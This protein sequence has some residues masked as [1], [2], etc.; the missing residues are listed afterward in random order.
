MITAATSVA[1]RTRNPIVPAVAGSTRLVS[2]GLSTRPKSRAIA[3]PSATS[4]T[5]VTIWAA[6]V[7]EVAAT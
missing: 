3:Q 4:S 2:D 7:A 6:V 5:T 1:S